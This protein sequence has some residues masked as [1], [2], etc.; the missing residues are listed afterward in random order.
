MPLP[1]PLTRHPIPGWKGTAF[2]KAIVD[3]PLIEVGD[4]SYYDD[5]RGPEHFVARCVR[6]HFDFVGDRLIIGKFVAIAQAAQ[7]IMNGANH[8][9]GGFSTFPFAMFGMAGAPPLTPETLSHRGDTVIGNDVWIGREAVIMPGVTVGDGAI[10]GTRAQVSRD[11]PPY[12]VVVGNPGKVV[13]LRFPPEI[14]AELLAIRW[15]DWE[16]EKIAR[17]L[18]VIAS[19]DIDALRAAV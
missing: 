5:S 12:A 17:N 18:S 2:L 15:W 6:Y 9:M 3:H 19:V 10:I 16:P 11:V 7:F 8:P 1:D 14:V 4:Y 13:K